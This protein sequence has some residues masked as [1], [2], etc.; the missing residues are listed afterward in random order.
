MT[1]LIQV[2]LDCSFI[3]HQSLNNALGCHQQLVSDQKALGRFP[4]PLDNRLMDVMRWLDYRGAVSEDSVVL[5]GL[6]FLFLG[7]CLFNA[8]G[9]MLTRFVGKAPQIGVRR[10]LG[11]RKSAVFSQQLIEVG[12]IGAGGGLLGLALAWLALQ[13][14]KRLFPYYERLAELDFTMVAAAIFAAV[15]TTVLAGLYPAWRVCRV[16]PAGYLRIQ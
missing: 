3:D 10:A 1:V 2:A 12:A 6:S 7:V 15:L 11:A 13:G 5:V 14:I 16:P 4:R 9:L 8:V